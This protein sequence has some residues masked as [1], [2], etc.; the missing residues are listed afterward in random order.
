MEDAA[1]AER[2]RVFVRARPLLRAE[3]DEDAQAAPL[4]GLAPRAPS[5]WGLAWRPHGS[6]GLI[7]EL[8]VAET[9]SA[10]A[11]C[12]DGVVEP[13]TKNAAV[14]AGC[15]APLVRRVLAGHSACCFAYGQTGSGKTYT[16][17]GTRSDPGVLP[18]AIKAVFDAVAA[19]E[20]GPD[21]VVSLRMSYLEICA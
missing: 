9:G 11:H 21:T 8:Q 15:V 10:R 3:V 1:T 12:F 20:A 4:L 5:P 14:F 2:I 6:D 16:M 7:D 13:L 19:K 17:L 18:C